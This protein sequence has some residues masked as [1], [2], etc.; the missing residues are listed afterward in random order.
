MT[1][2]G[3]TVMWEIEVGRDPTSPIL[4]HAEI[5]PFPENHVDARTVPILKSCV[6][7]RTVHVQVDMPTEVRIPQRSDSPTT[8]LWML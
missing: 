3:G 5:V 2:K 8:L 6:D 1:E 4:V 7:A